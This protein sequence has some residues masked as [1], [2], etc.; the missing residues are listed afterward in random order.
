[1]ATLDDI[2]RELKIS[3]STVS[4]ALSGA[5]DVSKSMRQTVLEK[6]VEMGYSRI[7]RSA[8]PPRLAVFVINMEYTKPEDFGYDLVM[9][10]RQAAEPSGYQVEMI[11]L[12]QQLQLDSHYDT[13]M[14]QNNYSGALLLGLSLL[15]PWMKDFETCKTPAI[16]YDNHI[17]TN[18]RVTHIG[19]DNAEGM[20]L[21][22]QYLKKLGHTKIGYLS[23]ALEAYVYRQRYNAF[24]QALRTHDMEAD[25]KQAGV[26]FFINECLSQHLPSILDAGCTA[27]VCSHDLLAHSAMIHCAQMGYRVPEDISIV[28]FDD[29]PICRY[30][31]PPLTTVRQ[32]RINIGKSAFYAMLNQLNNVHVTSLLLHPELIE[33]ASCTTVTK[34]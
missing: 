20:E 19:V 2:A 17:N 6:A 21:A 3:K 28:G 10:F 25:E 1:M 15:D 27:I 4:K 18:P 34:K 11:P 26:S 32:D 30:T 31:L 5:K 16:L 22:V 9:G 33:R 24:F 13:Y 12:T 8:E 23:S 14:V 7:A 29:I